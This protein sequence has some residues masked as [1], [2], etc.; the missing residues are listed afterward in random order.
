MINQYENITLILL[1]LLHFIYQTDELVVAF[2]LIKFQ[3]QLRPDQRLSST[4]KFTESNEQL[5]KI[6]N[7]NQVESSPTI[8]IAVTIFVI[9]QPAT[10]IAITTPIITINTIKDC[11]GFN[12]SI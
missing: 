8:A 3:G 9:K 11:F 12:K 5:I 1:V 10:V 4:V 6:A 2:K 7:V